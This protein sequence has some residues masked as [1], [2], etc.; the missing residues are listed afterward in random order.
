ME[1]IKNEDAPRFKNST[2]CVAT[3]YDFKGEKDFNIAGIELSGRYPEQGYALNTVSKELIYVKS[4]NGVLISGDQTVTLKSG[5]AALIQPNEKYYLE[6]TL[7]LVIS[8]AP[9][10]HLEQHKN[11]LD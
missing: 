6:G 3:E 10:W 8:S 5:D 2:S 9:A 7:E 4:G 1:Y 11:I